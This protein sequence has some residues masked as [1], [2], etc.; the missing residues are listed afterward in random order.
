MVMERAWTSEPKGHE[1]KPQVCCL[2]AENPK[3][4]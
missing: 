2:L 3:A 1:T 4:K